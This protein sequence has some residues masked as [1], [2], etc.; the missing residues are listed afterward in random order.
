[1]YQ[2]LSTIY[3]PAACLLLI[4]TSCRPTPPTDPTLHFINEPAAWKS[5]LTEDSTEH[6][7]ADLSETDLRLQMELPDSV[8]I[9][10]DTYKEWLVQQLMS[11]PTDLQAD[12]AADWTQ[13]LEECRVRFPALLPE[14]VDLLLSNDEP[15]GS[16]I[17][18]TRN[19]AVVMPLTDL[20]N[21]PRESLLNIFRH[22]LFHLISREHLELRKALYALANFVPAPTELKWP[23][24]LY[25]ARLA[26]PDAPN[27]DYML[28]YDSSYYLPILHYPEPID[29][30]ETTER[31]SVNIRFDYYKLISDSITLDRLPEWKV[32]TATEANSPY[33]IH[34]EE[35]L[36]E[37]F[38]LLL[39]GE[40][41]LDFPGE[42]EDLKEL[43]ISFNE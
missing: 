2:A 20:E 9:D 39:A 38:A 21:A 30:E 12:V 26:N 8:A 5:I 43:L 23:D 36:A 35:V 11:W 40:T 3:A 7:F 17:Y 4:L 42:L 24:T 14:R 22:E 1:M 27:Y 15:Y 34:A 33:L 37:H 28:D 13:V 6:Y 29:L 18:F 10:L 41:E 31:F 19:S 32:S 16:R 25:V